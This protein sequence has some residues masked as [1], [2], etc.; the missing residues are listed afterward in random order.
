MLADS[1]ESNRDFGIIFLKPDIAERSI[2][3]G[4]VGCVARIESSQQLP[5]GRANIV[6][7]GTRRFALVGFVDDTAPY[8]VGEVEYFEDDA[9]P[10]DATHDIATRVHAVFARVGRAARAMQDDTAPLPDL[11]ADP[12]ALS[13]AIAQYVDLEM[14]DKQ[15]LLSSRSPTRRLVRIHEILAPFVESIEWRA[16][17]HDRARSNGHGEQ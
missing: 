11:P 3:P 5:D 7:T 4:T 9:E 12:A 14:R 2:A 8:N 17:V 6:V 13:F 10:L 1:L 16:M 15:A